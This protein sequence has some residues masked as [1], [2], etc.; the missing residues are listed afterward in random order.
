M[1]FRDE[2]FFLSNMYPSPFTT[3]GKVYPSVEHFYQSCKAETEEEREKIRLAPTPQRAKVLGRATKLYKFWDPEEVMMMGLRLKFAENT[4]LGY[5]LLAVEGHI[6]EENWWGDTYWG[7]CNGK[8]LNRLGE[9][10]ME[11]RAELGN[12]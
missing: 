11:R 9:L 4:E 1:I 2:Y 3:L 12:Y 5:K 8:G 10:L 6:E 7:T